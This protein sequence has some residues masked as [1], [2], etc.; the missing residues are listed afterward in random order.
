MSTCHIKRLADVRQI[1]TMAKVAFALA[2][3]TQRQKAT[4]S[5]HRASDHSH[6]QLFLLC[7]VQVPLPPTRAFIFVD[8]LGLC[9]RGTSGSI[10]TTLQVYSHTKML[11]YIVEHAPII[12]CLDCASPRD[13]TSDRANERIQIGKLAER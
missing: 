11:I 12:P 8:S 10:L 6:T 9:K 4:G 7:K 13:S 2:I 3:P 5:S 1:Q